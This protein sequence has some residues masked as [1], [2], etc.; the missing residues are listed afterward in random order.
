MGYVAIIT[1]AILNLQNTKAT[2]QFS[3]HKVPESLLGA[4][5]KSN[6]K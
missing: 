3:V 5:F 4:L 1:E 2:C 6:K